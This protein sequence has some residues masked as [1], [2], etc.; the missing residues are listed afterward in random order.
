MRL[1]NSYKE[2][3]KLKNMDDTYI[4]IVNGRVVFGPVSLKRATMYINDRRWAFETTD[5]VMIARVLTCDG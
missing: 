3:K 1:R 4:V 5:T 2:L